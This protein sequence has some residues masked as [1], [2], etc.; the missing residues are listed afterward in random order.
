MEGNY[1]GIWPQEAN[2]LPLAFLE[3]IPRN[4]KYYFFD[5]Y[6]TS[7]ASWKDTIGE[8]V[9]QLRLHDS[10]QGHELFSSYKYNLV[11]SGT[12]PDELT[13]TYI[14][15]NEEPAENLYFALARP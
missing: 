12:V 6:L 11:R 9:I 10:W 14:L 13:Y 1:K 8:E 4:E 5:Y 15:R 2:N 3:T 7:G